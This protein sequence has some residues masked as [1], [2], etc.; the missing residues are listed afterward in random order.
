MPAYVI[1]EVAIHDREKMLEYQQFTPATIAAFDG[2]FI[3]R[4]GK[5]TPLEGDWR[6][7]R[8]V[9]IEFP[10]AG[11]ANEWWHS[12]I[13]AQPKLMRQAAATTRMIIVEGV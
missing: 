11:K 8:V 1:V 5:T 2:R 12:E 9:V 3:I 6:P 7:E 13:Y 10:T 4:G